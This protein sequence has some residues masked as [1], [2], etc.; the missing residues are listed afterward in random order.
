MTAEIAILNKTAVALAADSAVTI[1]A[2]QKEQKVYDSADKLFE[3]SNRNPIGIMIYN[4]TSYVQVPL[5]LLIRKFRADCQEVGSVKEIAKKF[6]AYLHEFGLSASPEI[7]DSNIASVL[8]PVLDV[9]VKRLQRKLQDAF[10][11]ESRPPENPREFVEQVLS[12]EVELCRDIYESQKDAEFVG[13]GEFAVNS[14]AEAIARE[15]IGDMFPAATELQLGKMMEL[16]RLILRKAIMSPSFTGVVIAGFGNKEL[17]PTLISFEID[18]IVCGQLKYQET[19]FVDIDRRGSRAQVIPFAQKEIV[20]R[21]LYGLDEDIERQIVDFCSQSVPTIRNQIERTINFVNDEQRRGWVQSVGAAERSFIHGLRKATFDEIRSKSRSEIEGMVEFMPKPELA[22]MA[23]ALV[24]LTSIK[25]RVSKG[26]ETV[27]GPIDVAVISQSEGFV[28]IKRKHY[29]PAELN[30]R[31][32]ERIRDG[33]RRSWEVEHGPGSNTRQANAKRRRAAKEGKGETRRGA[34]RGRGGDD[35][36]D[37][38]GA[39]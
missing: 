4:E 27:G 24:N 31:Y 1:S 38:E 26:F 5:P 36:G 23:E 12:E 8:H 11:R 13:D 20:E 9:I 18:G 14:E 21:F 22:K 17:F 32:F 3:L 29:F 39:L 2:G 30:S 37:G 28:W 10:T 6:L 15:L 7:L 25:R 19:N 34:K 33:V 16:S 35:E